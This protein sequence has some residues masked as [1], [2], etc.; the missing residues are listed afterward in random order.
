MV[1]PMNRSNPIRMMGLSSGMDTDSI[2]QQTLR[3]HQF[4]IDN[5]ARN[6]TLLQWRQ[7]T[8]NSLRSDI[9]ALRENFMRVNAAQSLVNRNNFNATV[10]NVTGGNKGAVSIQTLPGSTAGNMNISRVLSLA[11]GAHASSVGQV[12]HNSGGFN[13]NARLDSL[14]FAGN[15]RIQFNAA[16]SDAP[17]SPT[18]S[19]DSVRNANWGEATANVNLP[20]NGNSA[21]QPQAVKREDGSIALYFNNVPGVPPIE[22]SAN[23]ESQSAVFEHEGNFFQLARAANGAVTINQ[24]ADSSGTAMEQSENPFSV[25][26]NTLQFTQEATV[27]NS[28]GENVTITRTA[29]AATNDNIRIGVTDGNMS[30][31]TALSFTT[32]INFNGTNVTLNASDTITQMTSRIN[33][34]TRANGQ[35]GVTFSYNRLQDSFRIEHNT[36]DTQGSELNVTGQG[37]I[38]ALMFGS[39]TVQ[40]EDG[41]MARVEIDGVVREFDSNRFDFRGVRI[42]LNETFNTDMNQPVA[43]D[44]QVRINFTRDVE[45]P[46]QAIRD[47]VAAYNELI[48]RLETLSSERQTSAQRSFRPLTDN[49][50]LA[51][52]ERQIDDWNATAR[53]GIMRNDLGLESLASNMRQAFFN[54]IS[55][56]GLSASQIGLNTGSRENG[57]RIF[58][59]EDRLRAALEEDPE[60]IADVFARIETQD[61]GSNRGV[62]LIYNLDRMLG[63]FV[64]VTQSNSLTGLEESLRQTNLQIERMEARMFAEED[65]LLRQFAAMESAMSQMSQQGNWFNA[66]LG[67]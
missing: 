10:A 38:M 56:T 16:T 25:N 24:V 20:G 22:I 35:P 29:N 67:N 8:H 19:L 52:T 55:G 13:Q 7:E 54:E 64:N 59:D 27:Q 66:M 15:Q 4:R 21:I 34:E 44:S 14:T 42:T 26:L 36:T 12:S 47:F 33:T 1:N 65:R 30:T 32:S 58:I 62:G 3:M 48:T 61:D 43:A 6:R 37:N 18:I 23:G 57:G 2:I 49:E 31:G 28:A 45:G 60:R 17:G 41:S 11:S 51:M 63:Q 39:N 5:V 46:M 40:G 53:I 9:N 50:K